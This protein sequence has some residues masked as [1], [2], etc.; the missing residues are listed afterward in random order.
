MIDM[1]VAHE[2]ENDVSGTADNV[3]ETIYNISDAMRSY[4]LPARF[5]SRY[6]PYINFRS[7]IVRGSFL[8]DCGVCASQ[9][10]ADM[11]GSISSA[12]RFPPNFRPF[13]SRFK[14]RWTGR[15]TRATSA[16]ACTA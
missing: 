10:A 9:L 13:R 11:F 15:G 16:P 14:S 2:S 4:F 5:Y 1:I 7:A 6:Y 12:P 3:R 8:R